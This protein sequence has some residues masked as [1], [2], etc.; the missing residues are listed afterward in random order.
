MINSNCHMQ[1][2][3]YSSPILCILEGGIKSLRSA[4]PDGENDDAKLMN[5][6]INDIKNIKKRFDDVKGKIW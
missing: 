2:S 3:H 6:L 5:E 4:R 1:W